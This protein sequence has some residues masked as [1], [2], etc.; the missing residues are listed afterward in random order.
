MPKFGH[1]PQPTVS[2]YQT[3]IADELHVDK[4]KTQQYS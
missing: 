3:K 4:N 2:K 1:D